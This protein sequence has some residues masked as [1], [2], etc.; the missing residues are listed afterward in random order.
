M[1]YSLAFVQGGSRGVWLSPPTPPFLRPWSDWR[2]DG[3]NRMTPSHPSQLAVSST[4]GDVTNK[5]HT[6]ALNGEY[7][8]LYPVHIQ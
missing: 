3:R 5:R 4:S 7:V 6:T 8:N 1:G 2:S